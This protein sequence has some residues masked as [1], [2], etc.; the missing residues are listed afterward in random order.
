MRPSS[1]Q[2]AMRLKGMRARWSTHGS[3]ARKSATIAASRSRRWIRV[4]HPSLDAV[5]DEGGKHVKSHIGERE[6]HRPHHQVDVS[7]AAVMLICIPASADR[8]RKHCALA[9]EPA[10]LEAHFARICGAIGEHAVE[11]ALQHGGRQMP[12]H[13]ILQDE[14][15]RAIEPRQFVVHRIRQRVGLGGVTLFR[16]C[17]EPLR[18][19]AIGKMLGPLAGIET[20]RIKVGH[21]N[22]PALGLER[23]SSGA[24]KVSVKG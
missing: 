8:H 13:R 1:P 19:S 12:P 17:L 10:V 24:N 7:T 15:V 21:G 23:L 3:A 5:G 4:A 18:V 14:Q 20:D 11:P 2:S 9:G 16:L 6:V 22:A